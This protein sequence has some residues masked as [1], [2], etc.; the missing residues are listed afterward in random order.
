MTPIPCWNWEGDLVYHLVLPEQTPSNNE[1]KDMHYH[2]YKALRRR[3][4]YWVLEALKFRRPAAPLEMAGLVVVRYCA[5]ALDWDNAYGGLKPLQD[6]LVLPSKRNPDGLGLV[7]DDSPR[8]MPYP[9][10]VR[11]VKVRPDHGRTEV[12]IYRLS[13]Q[14]PGDSSPPG[15]L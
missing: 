7:Q 11:Q 8:F 15:T 12:F 14:P 10:F 6:C 13:E 4:H 9:P 2:A 3:W 1:I 5:G